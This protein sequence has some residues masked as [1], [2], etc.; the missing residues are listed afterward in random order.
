MAKL[1][2]GPV[3]IQFDVPA[4]AGRRSAKKLKVPKANLSRRHDHAALS[5]SHDHHAMYSSQ[6]DGPIVLTRAGLDATQ[7][8]RDLEGK[9]DLILDAGPSRLFQA[10]HDRASA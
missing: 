5:G 2:P 1:W 9:V 10:I 8:A 4:G 7:I 3:A 6:V